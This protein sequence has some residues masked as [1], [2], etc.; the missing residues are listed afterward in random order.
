MSLTSVPRE[1]NELAM[2]IPISRAM[3]RASSMTPWVPPR[4]VV[5]S[6]S[7]GMLDHAFPAIL[8]VPYSNA[9]ASSS[10]EPIVRSVP[11]PVDISY[12]YSLLSVGVA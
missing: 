6:L 10:T 1:I 8:D 4:D 5:N 7:S 12:A 11:S 3:S 2:L 9:A